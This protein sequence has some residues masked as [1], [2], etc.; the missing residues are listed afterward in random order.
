MIRASE[1]QKKKKG[2]GLCM[3]AVYRPK[4]NDCE[5]LRCFQRGVQDNGNGLA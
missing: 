3:D 5:A 4:R 2:K 1:D